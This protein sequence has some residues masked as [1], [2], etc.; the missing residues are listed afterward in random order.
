M[1]DPSA[2]PSGYSVFNQSN[3]ETPGA[4]KV[5]RPDTHTLSLKFSPTAIGS[6]AKY[7]WYSI[8]GVCTTYDR[9]PDTGFTS[10]QGKRC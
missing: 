10:A 6:P 9:A 5:G 4:V 8:I 3:P 7:R 2:S 1:V